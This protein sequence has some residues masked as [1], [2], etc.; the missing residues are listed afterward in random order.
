MSIF[1]QFP[2]IDYKVNGSNINT[3]LIDIYRHVDV[4]ETLIDDITSYRYY[5]IKDGERP[6]GVSHKLYGNSEYHWT[7]FVA[8]EKL[9]SL[10]DWPR[11]YNEQISYID[12][13][14]DE[15]SVLEFIPTQEYIGNLYTLEGEPPMI[16][17]S[18]VY[19][20]SGE[21]SRISEGNFNESR[22]ILR[23][24]NGENVI[25]SIVQYVEDLVATHAWTIR[26]EDP[27][28]EPFLRAP[29]GDLLTVSSQ[30]PW[31]ITDWFDVRRNLDAGHRVAT[32]LVKPVIGNSVSRS[33]DTVT[34]TFSE[35]H[36][37]T[38]GVFAGEEFDSEPFGYLSSFDQN[39]KISIS[40]IE[41]GSP[42][43]NGKVI[44][45]TT[46]KSLSNTDIIFPSFTFDSRDWFISGT[47]NGKNSYVSYG[48]SEN[49]SVS[50][51]W[52]LSWDADFYS[53]DDQKA[54]RMSQTGSGAKSGFGGSGVSR[55]QPLGPWY[56]DVYSTDDVATPDLVTNWRGRALRDPNI[57]PLDEVVVF[58][59]GTEDVNGT[60]VRT[61]TTSSGGPS[62]TKPGTNG[63]APTYLW[64]DFSGAYLPRRPY[65]WKI[66]FDKANNQSAVILYDG[67]GYA[68]ELPSPDSWILRQTY[69]EITLIPEVAACTAFVPD[70]DT[71]GS[72]WQSVGFDDSAWP[73]GSTGVGYDY[74]SLINLDV[75]AEMLGLATS[76]YVRVPFTVNNISDI[77]SLL[78]RM[79]VD[80]GFVA[81]V[82]GVRVASRKAPSTLDYNSSAT[83]FN[84]DAEAVVF[85]TFD[86]SAYSDELVIGD[87]ILAIH[88]LNHTANSSDL[89]IMPELVYTT[90][91]NPLLQPPAPTVS[92]SDFSYGPI[93]PAS[94]S[95]EFSIDRAVTFE[96][97][98]L[99]G[100][101][102]GTPVVSNFIT[103]P[104][105]S[106]GR[107]SMIKYNNYFNDIDFTDK[108]L[109]LRVK[110]QEFVAETVAYDSERLQVWVNN[111][112]HNS[113]LSNDEQTY[114]LDYVTDSETERNE[115]L[116]N[117]IL[118]WVR[119]HHR[120]VYNNLISDA[121]IIDD[122][123]QPYF[124]GSFNNTTDITYSSGFSISSYETD[125]DVDQ[126]TGIIDG[127]DFV[128]GAIKLYANDT[129]ISLLYSDYLKNVELKTSRSWL[130][131]YNAP[132][133]YLSDGE[134]VTAYDALTKLSPISNI[135]TARAKNDNYIT[136]FY[137]EEEENEAKRNIRVLKDSDVQP[138][139]DYYR[140]LINE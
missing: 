85:E 52:T 99:T 83:T 18:G 44:T 132:Y 111:I 103:Q 139:V 43:V 22:W 31:L 67:Y 138:F 40:G 34:I 134:Y 37:I 137:A 112:S 79:R 38:E 33:G 124:R 50:K 90:P 73:P 129:I 69:D 15:Y 4:N 107:D 41:G 95:N 110:N 140:N 135:R 108:N 94:S 119:N 70:D 65:F 8:N 20:G 49:T 77:T 36:D 136:Y 1:S 78:L 3:S 63:G 21:Y 98:G 102:S 125:S 130:K 47:I 116:T 93:Y 82:N 29:S 30:K 121:R 60:Y 106:F 55:L 131:S 80:D 28:K 57:P 58:G 35:D 96:V 68:D 76:I 56:D 23:K 17:I 87:N 6:D 88:G 84:E 104:S 81:Y 16:D 127:G 64:A 100:T 75:E 13:K 91:Q 113:F 62:Y 9:N 89:L 27:L 2:L 126:E 39:R 115:W 19:E 5:D 123:I 54:W 26:N 97:E 71:L 114:V 24:L 25:L 46:A 86:I 72:A 122:N 74:G 32:K 120:D 11:S 118:P 92:T 133:S 10:D 109:R 105:F 59:A 12:K 51:K 128:R 48:T 14:Y 117:S 61:G 101:L 66:S 42:D 7:F 45:T 53:N